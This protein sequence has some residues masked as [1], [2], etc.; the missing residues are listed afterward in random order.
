MPI[1]IYVDYI[2]KVEY[3]R[4]IDFYNSNI[5]VHQPKLEILDRCEGGFQIPCPS[6]E[7]DLNRNIKQ[8]RWN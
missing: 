8:L 4:I 1:R 2:E 7:N 5:L 3:E 6:G